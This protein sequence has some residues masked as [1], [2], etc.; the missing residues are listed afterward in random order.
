L[1]QTATHCATVQTARLRYRHVEIE[2]SADDLVQTVLAATWEGTLA[3]RPEA[4]P[5]R[6]HVQDEIR[7]ACRHALQRHRARRGPDLIALDALNGDDADLTEVEEAL[8]A[9]IP[10]INHETAD[11]ANRLAQELR[12]LAI[13]DRD[14][15]RVL[16]ALEQGR[17]SNRELAAF[18]ELE[19]RTID[20]ARKRLQRL[21]RRITPGLLAEIEVSIGVPPDRSASNTMNVER[22]HTRSATESGAISVLRREIHSF[23][24]ANERLR[25]AC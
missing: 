17:S 19:V 25:M 10:E 22:E 15:L 20:N 6:T 1:I 7:H 13:E 3:W 8:A 18:T 24:R 16:A 2:M 23:E 9:N 12:N 5:L 4:V 21:R 14:A 11:L